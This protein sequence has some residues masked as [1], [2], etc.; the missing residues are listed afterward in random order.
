[1]RFCI[2]NY[3]CK[4]NMYESEKIAFFLE[5]NGHE[6]TEEWED[7]D[8]FI[9]N[10]CVVTHKSE[11]R[12]RRLVRKV[13]RERPDM[14]VIVAGCL[15]ERGG[16]PQQAAVV[17]NHDKI[18]KILSMLEADKAG[19]FHGFSER[20]R[21][22]LKI[23]DG[24]NQFCSY[25]IIPHVR[26]RERDMPYDTVIQE[27][28]AMSSH[29]F[30]EIVLTGIHTGRS[31]NLIPIIKKLISMKGIERI[32]LSS[33]EVNEISG[34]L[35]RIMKNE[36]KFMDHL[37][38]PLQSGSDTVLR[39]MNRPY[40]SGSFLDKIGFIREEVPQAGLTT[41][42]IVGFPGED[43]GDFQDSLDILRKACFHRIHI[44]T[45]SPRP[46]TAAWK[47][48]E[49]TGREACVDRAAQAEDLM[50]ENFKEYAG[51]MKGRESAV[52]IEESNGGSSCGY[53]SEYIR[54]EVPGN[55][56]PGTIMPVRFGEVIK[57]DIIAG[58]YIGP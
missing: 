10:G 54:T 40:T 37:H 5:K 50:H 58:E 36:E 26:G 21:S 39:S 4:V 27:A 44:F 20:N 12:N 9:I 15:A 8:L 30:R 6:R 35:I 43:D 56:S 23:Q 22:F 45:F 34:E 48:E 31:R 3:G 7:A 24:C 19:L 29:G 18:E 32:R 17:G 2:K 46:G 25:C 42:L 11:R 33:I 57:N 49:R 28:E 52:L 1:M 53:S 51:M 47:M 38:I 16:F 41:D 55:Y 13:M 14:K